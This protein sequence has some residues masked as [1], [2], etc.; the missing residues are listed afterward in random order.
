MN[1]PKQKIDIAIIILTLV[2]VYMLY[3]RKG[4]PKINNKMGPSMKIERYRKPKVENFTDERGYVSLNFRMTNAFL[5]DTKLEF[6]DNNGGRDSAFYKAKLYLFKKSNDKLYAVHHLDSNYFGIYD[7]DRYAADSK[8]E[9][10]TVTD[11]NNT[12]DTKDISVKIRSREPL[13]KNILERADEEFLLLLRIQ[14][15]STENNGLDVYPAVS[16]IFKFWDINAFISLQN[17]TILPNTEVDEDDDD[18]TEIPPISHELDNTMYLKDIYD[19][20]VVDQSTITDEN[21]GIFFR[22]VDMTTTNLHHILY[23]ENFRD[24]YT[25][26]FDWLH[27]GSANNKVTLRWVSKDAN[28]SAKNQPYFDVPFY[29]KTTL[30]GKGETSFK[31][32]FVSPT[33]VNMNIVRSYS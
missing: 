33:I 9:S 11:V 2:L 25:G 24:S 31:S 4:V 17:A 7:N 3:K 1:I 20:T 5:G 6:I 18:T 12:P 32:T 21:N 30:N 23:N 26:N 10:V 14:L 16:K 22:P 28:D 15:D 8:I 29:V 27:E 13:F 19:E